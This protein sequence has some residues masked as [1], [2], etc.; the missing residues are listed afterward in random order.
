MSSKAEDAIR[1]KRTLEGLKKSPYP[2]SWMRRWH[3]DQ[4]IRKSSSTT[5]ANSIANEFNV[6]RFDPMQQP[7]YRGGTPATSSESDTMVQRPFTPC[8]YGTPP[9]VSIMDVSDSGNYYGEGMLRL[10]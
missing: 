9:T 5:S 8:Q 10:D 6:D 2:N 4:L 7:Q 1:E 3:Q